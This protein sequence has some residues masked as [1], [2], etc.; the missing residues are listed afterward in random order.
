MIAPRPATTPY[1]I[2]QTSQVPPR[3]EF[4]MANG[5]STQGEFHTRQQAEA[6]AMLVA[7]FEEMLA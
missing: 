7:L 5:K 1:E 6:T 2:V 4:V 3:F